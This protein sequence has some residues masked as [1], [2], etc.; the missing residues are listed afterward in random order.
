[1]NDHNICLADADLALGLDR[2]WDMLVSDLWAAVPER[3]R[4]DRPADAG[5]DL[6]LKPRAN[7]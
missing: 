5:A 3:R 1:M 6:V 7:D 4:G 2:A